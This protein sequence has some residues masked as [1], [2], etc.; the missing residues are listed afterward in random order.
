ML[1]SLKLAGKF[2]GLKALVGGSGILKRRQ[3]HGGKLLMT[4]KDIVSE[5]IILFSIFRPGILKITV[6]FI[7]VRLQGL[8]WRVE[9]FFSVILDI[10]NAERSRLRFLERTLNFCP[11]VSFVRIPL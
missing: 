1:L 3:S 6:P 8:M 4:H 5:Y 11:R 9:S 7:Q 10:Q 2:K